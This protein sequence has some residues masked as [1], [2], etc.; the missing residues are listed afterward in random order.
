MLPFGGLQ[1]YLTVPTNQGRIMLVCLMLALTTTTITDAFTALTPTFQRNRSPLSS[2]LF[3]APPHESSR[4]FVDEKVTNNP[5]TVDDEDDNDETNLDVVMKLGALDIKARLLD[6]VPRMMGAPDE[7][8][9]V[10]NYINAIE[11]KYTPAQTLDFFN[12]ATN[13]EWQLLFSTS[14]LGRPLEGFRLREM[15]QKVDP[16]NFEGNLTNVIQFDYAEEED[17]DK[18]TYDAMGSGVGFGKPPTPKSFD[19]SGTLSVVCNYNINQGSRMVIEFHD[20]YELKLAKGSKVPKNVPRLMALIKRSVP[21]ELFRPGDHAID[22]TYGDLDLRIV[23][24][25]GPQH[26]GVRDVFIRRGSFV[27]NPTASE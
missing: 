27:L 16:E 12:M 1:Q 19:I 24:M 26:E 7:L 15:Y 6:L 14:L 20:Q 10:Q 17:D 9:K 22:T 18:D 4:S 13:G 21:T 11:S 5:T 8:L 2:V 23:R 3:S 25:V